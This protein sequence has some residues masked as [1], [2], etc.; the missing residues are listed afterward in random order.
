MPET[1]AAIL[2]GKHLL[3][4]FCTKDPVPRFIFVL[5]ESKERN[6]RCLCVG[7][8]LASHQGSPNRELHQAHTSTALGPICSSTV[9]VGG[10]PAEATQLAAARAQAEW[11]DPQAASSDLSPLG[12][13]HTRGRGP[14]SGPSARL[15]CVLTL[16]PTECGWGFPGCSSDV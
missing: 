15:A 4:S 10:S 16:I 13:T 2:F 7:F 11:T 14:G 12:T 3:E 8:A 1:Q 9:T 6:D 5:A